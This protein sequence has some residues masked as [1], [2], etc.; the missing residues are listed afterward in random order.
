MRS[1]QFFKIASQAKVASSSSLP[2]QC[3]IRS[4]S[5]SPCSRKISPVEESGKGDSFQNRDEPRILRLPRAS[6][7]SAIYTS[8]VKNSR[9][10]DGKTFRIFLRPIKAKTMH[11]INNGPKY[12][13]G[14]YPMG[15][16]QPRH[17]KR[18]YLDPTIKPFSGWRDASKVEIDSESGN[19]DEGFQFSY[20]QSA[21]IKRPLLVNSFLANTSIKYTPLHIYIPVLVVTGKK[22]IDNRAVI[23]NKAKTKLLH[24]FQEGLRLHRT[25]Q[26]KK[27]ELK[28]PLNDK[29]GDP[30]ALVFYPTKQTVQE[31]MQELIESCLNFFATMSARYKRDP[32]LSS[33]SAQRP[34]SRKASKFTRKSLERFTKGTKRDTGVSSGRVD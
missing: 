16:L 1:L 25:R 13:S 32:T 21:L 33:E 19:Q 29:N 14:S 7:E 11:R 20:H 34:D 4:F 15:L 27:D 23:R 3:T 28:W 9:A 5:A 31:P 30:L 26:N 2:F 12:L 10:F 24:A 17:E 6:L 22:S 8:Q 18:R